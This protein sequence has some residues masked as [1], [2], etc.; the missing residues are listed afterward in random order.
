MSGI[1]YF[2]K[3]FAS[4]S[5]ITADDLNEIV[6]QL[7]LLSQDRGPG[8]YC[9]AGF[10]PD[11]GGTAAPGAANGKWLRANRSVLAGTYDFPSKAT[12]SPLTWNASTERFDV[13]AGVEPLTFYNPF[14]N[15][16][17]VTNGLI[18]VI[19]AET[20]LWIMVWGSC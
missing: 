9:G 12:G 8:L 1:G 7:E 11:R 18:N 5:Q 20:D 14:P 10:F 13:T 16:S 2:G 19:E 15:L 3:R 17:A 4:N 6:R